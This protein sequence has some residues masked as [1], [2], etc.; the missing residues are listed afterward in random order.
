MTFGV[1]PS[2]TIVVG[3]AYGDCGKGS[4]VDYLTRS[5]GASTIVRFSGGPQAGHNV[6]TSDGRHHTFSQFGSGTFAG[7]NTLLSRFMLIEPYAMINE[8]RHL[9]AIGCGKVWDRLFIDHRC[10][11]ITPV[12]Q[13]ANRLR[14]LARG[15]FAHGTCGQG[16]GEAVEDDL[17]LPGRTLRAGEMGDTNLTREKLHEAAR[18]KAA[19]LRSLVSQ[20]GD[21]PRAQRDIQTIQQPD[22]IDVAVDV[23]R[24]VARA[25]R[26][27]SSDE[28][29][30]LIRKGGIVFEGAQGVLLDQDI[31]FHPHTTW[32][33]T[34]PNNAIELLAE[35]EVKHSPRTIGVLRCYATRHGIGPLVSEESARRDQLPELH[36]N[37]RGRQG[38]FRV[39]VFDAV[40]ARYALQHAAVDSIALTHTDRL[41]I[42][43]PRI[44][45]GYEFEG[46]PFQ[47]RSL[48]PGDLAGRSLQTRQL[49]RCTPIYS[50]FDT[51][52]PQRFAKA[53]SG[54]LETHVSLFA[55]GPTGNYWHSVP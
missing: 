55:T 32:S 12:H 20:L 14:E 40:A 46:G 19:L 29:C 3:L 8:A 42:L 11:V 49:M 50:A 26:M 9:H 5:S 18:L 16:V 37:D 39:G 31:G 10:I 44:C 53:I 27:L 6:V 47:I 15:E 48:P 54:L 30:A 24:D 51:A 25:A 43:P 45:S 17:Q 33:R 22:W 21:D 1:N 28:S 35:A 36:N 41:P 7:A 23:Y 4:L 38:T 13:A 2:L 34:T 52:N